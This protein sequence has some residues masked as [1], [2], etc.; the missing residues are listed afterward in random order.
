MKINKEKIIKLMPEIEAIATKTVLIFGRSSQNL[1]KNSNLNVGE[2]D[3]LGPFLV[4]NFLKYFLIIF[5]SFGKTMRGSDI[6]N[7]K[8]ILETIYNQ[9]LELINADANDELQKFL[10]KSLSESPLRTYQ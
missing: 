10:D 2:Q 4:S 5:E 6:Y 8:E 1:V 3:F 7:K 9:T